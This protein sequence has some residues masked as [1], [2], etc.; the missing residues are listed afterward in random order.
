MKV[1]L[2]QMVSGP[3]VD[4]NIQSIKN[5]LEQ[6][7]TDVDLLVLP[8]NFACFSLEGNKQLAQQEMHLDGPVVSQLKSWAVEYDLWILAGSIA[9]WDEKTQKF[10]AASLLLN[11][12]GELVARYNKIHLFD[13]DVTDGFG[14][15]RESDSYVAGD[16]VV[17]AETPWGKLG[18]A[19]CYDLRFPEMF[20]KL[21]DAG[22]DFVVL[23]SAFTWVTGQAHWEVLIRARAIEN[24]FYMLA[25]NQGGWHDEER[26]TWGGTMVVD[27]WGKIVDQAEDGHNLIVATLDKDLGYE[28]KQKM[29][30]Q[31]HRRL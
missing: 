13:V 4:K 26:R 30:C 5:S 28:L 12:Q 31:K 8:E 27:P 6:L 17:V 14:S 29:P 21:Q 3:D 23:P 7:S 25:C 9:L 22:A 10:Y 19:I 16:D 2:L 18:L 24:Q 1:A 20:R 11:S 15:Y